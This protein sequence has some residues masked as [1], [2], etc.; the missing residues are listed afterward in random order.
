MTSRSRPK[1]RYAVV[2]LGY[3]A[4][5]AV[6]P[7][8]AHARRNSE[9]V[10]L[11]SGDETKLA[12]LGRRYGVACYGYSD[13]RRLVASGDIDAVYIALPNSEHREAAVLAAESGVHVLTEKPMA[14]TVQDCEDMIRAAR[15]GGVQL[16]VA[17]RLHFERANLEVV[18][19]A[20]SG[21][22]G[23]LR[24]FD[25]LFGMQVREGDI[26]LQRKLGGGALGDLGIYCINAARYVF[27]DEPIEVLACDSSSRDA[28]FAEVPEMTSAILRFPGE[29]VATFTCSF[30]S[31]D[32]AHFQVTGTK[33]SLRLEHAFEY[34][35]P[36]QLEVTVAG[37]SRRREF[38]LR[39]QFAPELLYFSDCILNRRAP[40][41]SGLEGMAD[42]RIIE[43][44]EKSA[45]RGTWI[46]LGDI[47]EKKRRPTLAQEIHRPPVRKPKL[48][49]T[50]SPHIET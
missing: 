2:G 46:G 44:L 20:R 34:S 49:H 26:R 15:T 35:E 45:D 39:D 10:A 8:F 22:L 31:A 5:N 21:K 23:E 48:V 27:R 41:P 18:K 38:P 11:V 3:I 9:L 29:R 24:F 47:P 42:V 33:G 36:M 32:V 40:E 7:A 50:K 13:Y 6:L 25:A 28:R 19:L 43:A 1:V 16:M 4:Q 30:G 12:K 14:V 37:K 17:Y